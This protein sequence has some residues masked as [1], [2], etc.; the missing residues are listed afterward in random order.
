[1]DGRPGYRG[2]GPGDQAIASRR[3][4]AA[5]DPR[6]DGRPGQHRHDPDRRPL[7]HRMDDDDAGRRRQPG[8]VVGDR[9]SRARGTIR[10]AAPPMSR[11]SP[12]ATTT[13]GSRS[14]RPS[15]LR[16]TPGGR[17]SRPSPTRR[18]GSNASTRAAGCCCRGRSRSN[19]ASHG[20][21]SSP[22]PRAR[23]GTG[24]SAREPSARRRPR[25]LLPAVADGSGDRAGPARA[26][27]RS[28]PRLEQPDRGRLLPTQRRARQ[29][30][31]HLVGPG[32][33]VGRLAA[34][35]RPGRVPRVRQR[36]RRRQRTRPALPSH[37]PAAGLVRGSPDRDPLGPARLR[38]AIRTAA[39]PASGCRRPRSTS[40]RC[41]CSPTRAPPTRSWRPGSWWRPISTR[42]ARTGSNWATGVRWS[43]PPTTPGSPRRSP[44]SRTRP[45]MPTGSRTSGSG[46]DSPRPTPAMARRHSSSSPPTASSTA[47]TSRSGTCSWHASWAR[48][49]SAT[50]SR[51]LRTSCKRTT[52]DRFRPAT[53][54]ERTSWS[55]HHGVARWHE[56]CGCVPDGAWKTP[57]RASFDRLA[58]AIDSQTE[59]IARTLPGS[60]DPWA[61]RDA[62]V[63]VVV[64]AMDE[65]AFAEAWLGRDAGPDASRRFLTVMAAQRWRLAM[66]ASCG[67]FWDRTSGDGP[68]G[69]GRDACR[70]A[71]G[72]ALGYAPR[73]PPRGRPSDVMPTRVAWTFRRAVS[74]V[75]WRHGYDGVR[76][77]R[78]VCSASD[79]PTVH[80]VGAADFG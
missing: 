50:R 8:G 23:I 24:R 79:R 67:W 80:G 18:K 38:A 30:R 48:P 63:D 39:R 32:T 27:G 72:R 20:P 77:R 2:R 61:A 3:R 65:A 66:F 33:H 44:S 55:C 71:R 51:P 58:E 41:A 62:Y 75:A 45:G 28:R 5:P 52:G 10:A 13:S 47:T 73:R 56:A 54:V 26:V 29:P 64:G 19:H 57:L 16:P 36:G 60:P 22:T 31:P 15:R 78:E 17:R 46:R 69:Q 53:L 59:V 68:R 76:W 21:W 4:P 1:M 11:R 42:A 34:G 25:P 40:R 14:R 9:R 7:R 35:R 74:S 49:T 70:A 12:R 37:D 43:S 6:T